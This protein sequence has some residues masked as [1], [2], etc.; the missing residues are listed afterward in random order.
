MADSSIKKVARLAGVSIATVSRCINKPEKVTEQTRIKVQSAIE[1]TG[2]TPNSLAQRFRSGKTHQVLVAVPSIGDPFFTKVMRGVRSAANALGY[3]IVIRETRQGM[4]SADEINV[5]L[6]S[7]QADGLVLLNNMTFVAG[8]LNGADHPHLRPPAVQIDNA[9][10]VRE[11]TEYLIGQGHR[12]IGMICGRKKPSSAERERGF[13][14]TMQKARLKISNSWIFDAENSLDG[15]RHAARQILACTSRPTAVFCVS[16]ELAIGCMHEFQRAGL[17]VPD[18]I[19]VV[20]FDDIRY[21]EVTNPPL[22][23]VRQPAEEMGERIV[24]KLCAA[25]R[26]EK[27]GEPETQVVPHQLVI[28][29]S[30][31]TPRR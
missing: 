19:S 24:R 1:N 2:Y 23:T 31:A 5:A 15:G 26:E 6:E 29:Q 8:R 27:S 16:D 22:T 10:A 18:D 11:M 30:V 4:M 25:I 20:G 14:N 21:A 9:A 12:R 7:K 17:Q 3:A 28:R 13:R